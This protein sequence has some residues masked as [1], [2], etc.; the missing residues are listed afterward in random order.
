MKIV[1][2]NRLSDGRV[3]YA[4]VDNQPVEH[5]DQASVLDETAAEG[6]LAEVAGRPNVFVNPYLV[7]VLDHVPSGRDRLKE[8][9]RSAGP[10]VGHS[11]VGGV[12]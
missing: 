8:R 7:E 6:V 10:T 5:I 9:I 11:V 3:I 2:A 4:G 1:T 12:G